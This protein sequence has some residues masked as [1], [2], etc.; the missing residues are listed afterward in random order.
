MLNKKSIN[1]IYK[2]RVKAGTLGLVL[3][4]F[5]AQPTISSFLA[6]FTICGLGLALRAWACGHLKKD[7]SLAISGPYRFTRNPLYLG[8]LIIGLSVVITS[9]SLIVAIYFV[10]YFFIFYPVIIVVEKEKMKQRFPE[11]YNQFEEHVPL[12]FPTLK[13]SLPQNNPRFSWS[14]Y[15]QNK[16]WRAVVA[17]FLFW[18]I[19]L[20]KMLLLK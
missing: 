17:G 5:F 13:P 4:L 11:E 7:K 1:L 6:G 14:L 16:E 3:A 10:L 20:A 2:W 15:L 8:N 9:L 19:I 12:F 18:G